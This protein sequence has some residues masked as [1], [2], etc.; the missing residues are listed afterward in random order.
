MPLDMIAFRF[1]G[2]MMMRNSIVTQLMFVLL[3]PLCMA[4]GGNNVPLPD[5][6]TKRLLNDLQITVVPT[7]R[8]G[9]SMTIGLVVR[10]GS[11]FDT[12]SKGGLANLVSRMAN[13]LLPVCP[14]IATAWL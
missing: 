12:E 8:L 1:Q 11:A 7:E 5:L 14:R 6:H 9:E 4:S 3:V 13:K 2:W 10:Y